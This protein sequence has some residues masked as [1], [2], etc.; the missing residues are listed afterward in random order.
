MSVFK[1]MA[2]LSFDYIPD[3]MVHREKQMQRLFSLFRPVV[4]ANVSQNA[5]LVGSVGTGKTHLSRRFSVDFCKFGEDRGRVV[6]HVLVNC[7][8][9]M[10]DDA[11]LLSILKHFDE[12]FPERGF[13]IAE[14]L[15]VLRRQLERRKSHLLI[16]LDE[17][18]ILIKRPENDLLYALTRFDEEGP[19]R[20]SVST[21]LISQQ[22]RIMDYLDAATRSTFKRTNVVHFDKY[23]REELRDILKI[24]MDLA[25]YP[26]TVQPEALDLMADAAAD[27]GDARY[28]IELLER[29]GMLA[30]EE[31]AE[32]VTPEHV[33]G[34]RASTHATIGEEKLD[35][36]DRPRRVAL[37]AIARRLRDKAYIT[38]GEAEEA[39]A[40]ACEEFGEKKRAH[41]QFWKYLQDLDALGFIEATRSAQGVPGRTTLI[42]VV[43]VPARLL[44]EQVQKS[45]S[46]PSP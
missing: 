6:D 1:D 12:R 9:R 36:L 18:D 21:I 13:S 40:V 10:S 2:K 42:S 28:A 14:K 30:D 15:N 39:Y 11:V 25:F 29:S 22:S 38:T 46:A 17:A 44:E 8:Q 7:R 37:L 32:E 5:F 31:R 23:S 4:E 3:R 41:T 35:A 16:V 27:W 33:R 26:G 19:M 20:G 43:E 45:L 24:R 34:A